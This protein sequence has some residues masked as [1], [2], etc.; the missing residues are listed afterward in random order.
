[1]I[2]TKANK[3]NKLSQ[4]EVAPTGVLLK[5]LKKY[6]WCLFAIALIIVVG[7]LLYWLYPE[8]PHISDGADHREDEANY[9]AGGADCDPARTDVALGWERLRRAKACQEAEERH[10]VQAN[11]AIHQR[12]A[13]DAAKAST[14]FAYR[15]TWIVLLGFLF[16]LITMFSAIA[17]ALFAKA[18]AEQ[19]QIGVKTARKANTLTALG[20]NNDHRPWLSVDASIQTALTWSSGGFSI[21]IESSVKNVG[22]SPAINVAMHQHVSINVAGYNSGEEWS[23]FNQSM[24]KKIAPKEIIFP[25]DVYQKTKIFNFTERDIKKILINYPSRH[26]IVTVYTGCHYGYAAVKDK[27][28]YITML[29][30]TIFNIDGGA[31]GWISI[32]GDD[33]D[34]SRMELRKL[35]TRSTTAT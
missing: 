3:R 16:G 34:E 32:C 30:Q 35:P 19:A 27:G 26:I 31:D 14:D 4:G 33:I 1:M 29:R 24:L 7:G 15:Q 17:A 28:A 9:R 12:R 25:N 10:R 22:K 2:K 18:A 13:A 11:E 23:K 8:K 20:Q 5:R 6:R 21:G